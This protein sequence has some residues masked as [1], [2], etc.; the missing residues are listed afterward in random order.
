MRGCVL[1]WGLFTI[2]PF[3]FIWASIQAWRF[4][5]KGIM[6]IYSGYLLFGF[7]GFSANFL[8][9]LFC[10]A[11]SDSGQ[12]ALYAAISLF[13]FAIGVLVAL[14]ERRFKKDAT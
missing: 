10:R 1:G 5:P 8:R 9:L 12:D 4:V 3:M 13:I 11:W 6:S 14:Q 7:L 2:V